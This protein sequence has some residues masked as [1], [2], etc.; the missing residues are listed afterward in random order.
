[1]IRTQIPLT[2]EQTEKLRQIAAAEGR[3]L[4][5]LIRESVDLYVDSRGWRDRAGQRERALGVVGRFHSGANDLGANHD[6][7]LAEALKE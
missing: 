3:S 5:D 4:A 2:D 7:H 6:R 1:M